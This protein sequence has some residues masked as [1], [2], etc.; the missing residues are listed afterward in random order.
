MG[1]AQRCAERNVFLEN[2]CCAL[3]MA[4]PGPLRVE[5]LRALV[6]GR[7]GLNG[8][9]LLDRFGGLDALAAK[10]SSNVQDGLD[11]AAVARNKVS[12]FKFV[13]AHALTSQVM[14]GDNIFPQPQLKSFFECAAR[15]IRACSLTQVDSS[16]AR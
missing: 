5:E 4:R 14:Y 3:S 9:A 8:Q 7:N 16:W 15:S 10:I 12:E 6:E 1:Q 2:S 11:E 13:A